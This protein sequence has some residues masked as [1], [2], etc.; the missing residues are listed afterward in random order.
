MLLRTLFYIKF[1]ISYYFIK[2]MLSP[3]YKPDIC[4]TKSLPI[5]SDKRGFSVTI[6]NLL[7]IMAS[8]VKESNNPSYIELIYF[9]FVPQKYS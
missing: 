1:I 4:Q 8:I 7:T 5:C 2:K 6:L 3:F 9:L